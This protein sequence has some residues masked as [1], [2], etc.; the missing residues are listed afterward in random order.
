MA[1]Q[2]AEFGPLNS[3]WAIPAPIH[4]SIHALLV[5][6]GHFKLMIVAAHKDL[7]QFKRHVLFLSVCLLFSLRVS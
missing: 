6:R 2:T 4:T 3:K 7:E 5:Q 1:I